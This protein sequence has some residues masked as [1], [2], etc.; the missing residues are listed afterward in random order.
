MGEMLA[1]RWEGSRLGPELE[2]EQN[3]PIA[4]EGLV[5]REDSAEVNTLDEMLEA[6]GRRARR[7]HVA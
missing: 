6:S 3:E 1:D 2:P 7:T 4:L 5:E